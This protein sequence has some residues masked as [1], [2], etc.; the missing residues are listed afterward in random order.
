M[1]LVVYARREAAPDNPKRQD[2]VIYRDPCA[3]ELFVRFP[4]YREWRPDRR[5]K[6][7]ML[8]C[9]TWQLVWLTGDLPETPVPHHSDHLFAAS[10]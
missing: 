1:M 10:V 8:N 5:N 9:N 2:V 6:A 4:W 7:I 3:Q